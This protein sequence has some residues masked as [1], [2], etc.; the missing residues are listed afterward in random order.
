MEVI[1]F[2]KNSIDELILEDDVLDY[3]RN[4]I[5]KLLEAIKD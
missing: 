5:I 1:K 2:F 3:S 4:D